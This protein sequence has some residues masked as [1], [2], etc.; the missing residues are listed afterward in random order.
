MIFV[1]FSVAMLF[2]SNS[3][4]INLSSKFGNASYIVDDAEGAGRL[5][6]VPI[7]IAPPIDFI[8]AQSIPTEI[9]NWH[10]KDMDLLGVQEFLS[11][12]GLD[13][14]IM[15]ELLDKATFDQDRSQTVLPVTKE[16]LLDLPGD[17]RQKIY[18]KLTDNHDN[19]MQLGAFRFC[20][21]DIDEWFSGGDVTSEVKALV[22]KYLY[23]DGCYMFF[24]DLP[25]ILDKIQMDTL[26]K[27]LH[28]LFRQST[29]LVK[30]NI[31]PNSNVDHLVNYWS[32]GGR[33]K[34]VGS[35]LESMMRIDG[36]E[37]IDIVHL[38]PPFARRR[39]YT[40]PQPGTERLGV[41]HRDCHWTA[42]NFFNI[43]PDDRFADP[44]VV[45]ASLRNDYF[46]VQ[47]P[48]YGDLVTYSR[49]NGVIFHS[50]NYIAAG[51]VYT[52]TGSKAVWPWLITKIDD[53]AH[54][55]PKDAPV[56]IRYFRRLPN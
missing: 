35:L 45:G 51:L 15:R 18:L 4:S 20:G 39:L 19:N 1:F 11:K 6:I 41:G 44:A 37:K 28:I 24:A 16:L 46:E 49:S 48:I 26:P 22:A 12:S 53:M 56:L 23:R 43:D 17:V 32:L 10:F 50:A 30:L 34:D 14:V 9:N 3:T 5:S 42:Y 36:G 55:Y 7:T 47:K 8:R 40:Y 27:L 29:Y 31:S 13:P 25:L 21:R 2:T 54:F 52:K 38:L 33:A